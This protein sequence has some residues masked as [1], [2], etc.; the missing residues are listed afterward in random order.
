MKTLFEDM[1]LELIRFGAADILTTS[2]DPTDNDFGVDT[3]ELGS[4]TDVP[5]P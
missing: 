2:G 4:G 1:E 3:E 5:M